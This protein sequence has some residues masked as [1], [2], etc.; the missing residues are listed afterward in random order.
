MTKTV[1]TE[2]PASDFAAL[3]SEIGAQAAETTVLAKALDKEPDADTT[4]EAAAAEATDGDAKDGKGKP[5]DGEEPMGKA[6]KIIGENGEEQEGI[7][8]GPLL[9]SLMDR[10]EN[11]GK[12]TK[13]VFEAMFG[14][15][16]EQGTLLKSL[17]EQVKVL[18]AQGVGRRAV[19]TVH[20]KGV[21]A[22]ETLAKSLGTEVEAEKPG[23]EPKEFLAK[24][25]SLAGEGKLDFRDVNLCETLINKGQQPLPHVAKAVMAPA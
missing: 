6:L 15:I 7:D 19:L 21:T 22:A 3:L 1:T 14:V 13:Q 10:V 2:A 8:A 24:A 16:K 9:K 20:D 11:G 5:A 17:T 25:L 23:M 18:G 4:I 12:E